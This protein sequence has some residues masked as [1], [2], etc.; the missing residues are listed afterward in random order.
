MQVTPY[1]TSLLTVDSGPTQDILHSSDKYGPWVNLVAFSGPV[2]LSPDLSG[3]ENR[4]NGFHR[5]PDFVS[6]LVSWLRSQCKPRYN[7]CTLHILLHTTRAKGHPQRTDPIVP[8]DEKAIQ[9]PLLFAELP[10]FILADSSS[11]FLRIA[12]ILAASTLSNARFVAA[13]ICSLLHTPPRPA[14]TSDA[15]CFVAESSSD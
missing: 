12:S 1:D 2:G 10:P 3:S 6:L 15:S 7:V 14:E 4:T 9:D 13:S 11:H 5:R 8:R